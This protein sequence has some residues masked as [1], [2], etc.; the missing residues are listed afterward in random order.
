MKW[1]QQQASIPFELSNLPHLSEEQKVQYKIQIRE[2]E[3]YM[4]EKKKED[5]RA[6]DL[7][8]RA[9]GD[10]E[11]RKR[12]AKKDALAS[13]GS[14][15]DK[16]GLDMAE[17]GGDNS[18]AWDVADEEGGLDIEDGLSWEK[19]GSDNNARSDLPQD[20]DLRSN[21]CPTEPALTREKKK[22]KKKDKEFRE[23]DNDSH[24]F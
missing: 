17:E 12:K 9:R 22:K 20:C 14:S 10:M 21:L 18:T 6:M 4:A 11:R 5:R 1:A 13:A 24:E 16:G 19:D 2:R 15:Y 3:E 8:D 7:E 23:D